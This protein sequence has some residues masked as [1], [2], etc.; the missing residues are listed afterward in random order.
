MNESI[1]MTSNH[2]NVNGEIAHVRDV[3]LKAE[4]DYFLELLNDESVRETILYLQNCSPELLFQEAMKRMDSIEY[5]EVKE[6]MLEIVEGEITLLLAAIQDKALI[7]EL[8][9]SYDNSQGKGLS[10]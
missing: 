6:D 4:F 8:V 1:Q 9:L 7:K 10:R 3:F 5:G 2:G